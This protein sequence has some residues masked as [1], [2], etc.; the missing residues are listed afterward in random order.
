MRKHV[1]AGALAVAVAASGGSLAL[2]TGVAQ[3]GVAP[4]RAGAAVTYSWTAG[5]TKGGPNWPPSAASP[6][7]ERRPSRAG[8]S[9]PATS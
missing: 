1:V 3:A 9:G 6:P 2:L 5:L 4:H 8:P 7:P